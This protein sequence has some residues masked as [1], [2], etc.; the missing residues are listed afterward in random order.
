MD[1]ADCIKRIK[2]AI[3]D[4]NT[5]D[6]NLVFSLEET[7]YSVEIVCSS[8]KNMDHR[9]GSFGTMV[10]FSDYVLPITAYETVMEFVEGL[11]AATRL[12]DPAAYHNL[13]A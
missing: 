7:V 2:K 6:N 11:R 10:F 9:F 12:N 5:M 8:K 3:K 4:L 13:A 1:K